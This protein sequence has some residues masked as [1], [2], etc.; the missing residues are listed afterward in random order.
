MDVR[1]QVA[2][3][4]IGATQFGA[5]YR[6]RDATRSDY[7]LAAQAFSA[8]LDDAGMAKDEVDGLLTARVR[9]YQHMA[10]VLGIRRPRL[11]YGLDGAGRMSAVA[12]QAAMNAILTGQAETVALVYGN[13]GRSVKD[14]YGGGE[15]LAPTGHYDTAYGMTSPGAYVALMYQRY[16]H[17]YG[18]PE[19]A[20]APVAIANRNHARR[21]DNAVMRDPLTRETYL[22][23]RYI[24]EPLRLYDYCLINDGGV[25]LI[26]TSRARARQRG[27]PVV[28]ISATAT[29]GDLTNLYS[30]D[31]FYYE[32]C[33]DVARRVYS[34]AGITPQDVDVAQI[35]D[36]FTPTVLF[37]LDGFGFCAPGQAWEFVR[38]GN[39]ELGGY[40]PVNTSG[41]HTSESYM[42]GWALHVEAVRQLRGDAGARQVPDCEVA[43]YM[44]A[45][46]ITSSHILRRDS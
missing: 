4:G 22:A 9:S 14:T 26:L 27:G 7:D 34:R 38:E 33:Q 6:Q 39:I 1:D 42:Q 5:L 10:D 41:G 25:A 37:S 28:T 31:D 40:L 18:T 21:N 36:N 3:V 24:T 15:P 19:D 20:L 2:I 29:C 11:C 32:S 17:L 43:Q 46:P 23:S 16:A 8:A 45:A 30:S 35:Y 44:C 13:N 12:V